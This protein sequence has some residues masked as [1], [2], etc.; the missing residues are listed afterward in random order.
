[1]I[2]LSGRLLY[3]N[4][5]KFSYSDFYLHHN[6]GVIRD[7]KLVFKPGDTL[8]LD[9]CYYDSYID[10]Y[11]IPEITSYWVDKHQIEDDGYTFVDG[12]L[13]AY[14]GEAEVSLVYDID[15]EN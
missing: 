10:K 13:T 15:D 12:I 5:I 8:T 14:R 9:H 11:C 4:G 2:F 3:V 1:M 7:T 6:N